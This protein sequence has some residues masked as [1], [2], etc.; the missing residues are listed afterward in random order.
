LFAQNPGGSFEADNLL[1]ID[2]KKNFSCGYPVLAAAQLTYDPKAVQQM[3]NYIILN[4]FQ[5]T[6]SPVLPA[7]L[8]FAQ[9]IF[10]GIIPHWNL[11]GVDCQS[12]IWITNIGQDPVQIMQIGMKLAKEV[13][14][15]TY[16]YHLVG[17]CSLPLGKWVR[18]CPLNI[19]AVVGGMPSYIDTF[20]LTSTQAMA[21]VQDQVTN[22]P[23]LHPGATISVKLVLPTNGSPHNNLYAVMPELVVS[24]QK[25]AKLVLD[26]SQLTS[27]IAFLDPRT[28]LSCY[29]L[30]GNTFARL[31]EGVVGSGSATSYLSSTVTCL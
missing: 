15:N 26:F 14:P 29:Q 10:A 8:K 27:T 7:S 18:Y 13:S 3:T 25:Q 17:V 6:S 23:V 2:V 22:Q 16:A 5:D 30:H 11:R 28:Q 31:T 20:H 24:T 19:Q 9:G 4:Y 12:L 21:V 1:R